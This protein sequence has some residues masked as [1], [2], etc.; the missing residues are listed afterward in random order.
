MLVTVGLSLAGVALLQAIWGADPRPFPRPAWTRGVTRIGGAAVPNDRCCSLVG[1]AVLVLLA[2]LAFL[3]FTRVGLV[4]RAG[5][6]D[7]AMVTALGIDVRKAFTLVFAI[8]GAAAA[9]AGALGGVYFGSVSPGQGA[10]A[11]DLRV[12]RRGDRRDGLGGRL[13]AAPRSRS[14][15][16]SSS[17]TTTHA[18]GSA[19]SAWSRCWRSCCWSGARG[20]PAWLGKASH[21]TA[22][23]YRRA[24]L[25]GRRSARSSPGLAI[26][27]YSTL[28]V[29]GILDG[30]LNS[31]GTLQLL[32]ICLVFGGL[33]AELRPALRPHRPALVRARAVLRRRQSTAPTSLVTRSGWPLWLAL[34]LAAVVGAALA[35]VLGAV[36]LRT[37][38]IAFAMVTLAFAQVGAILVARDLGGLTGGEEGLPLARPACRDCL[39][40]RGQHGQPVLAGARPTSAVVVRW[41]TGSAALRTGR[42]LAGLRDDE[43]RVG[44][45][46]P[47]PV[48]VPLLAFVLA[49]APGRRSAAWS[50]CC[51]SAAPRPHVTTSD[52]HPRCW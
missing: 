28:A 11:A 47:G 14:A 2:L 4:I 41:C 31:P 38:G 39:R 22:S 51:W 13:G 27:P 17:S 52:A 5:V 7:R 48:P 21:D 37:T 9:L 8:G 35:A 40:R 15:C 16:C 18:P 36:A 32:A 49:G 10:L 26:L 25:G 45:L 19:T 50:T 29:P 43:R 44:V 1:A 30:P 23:W 3:R 6:E 34:A 12:H 24:R 20:A 33:A 42:V 46:G